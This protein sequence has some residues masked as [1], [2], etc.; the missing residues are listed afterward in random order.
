MNQRIWQ[1][2]RLRCLLKASPA[3]LQGRQFGTTRS[4]PPESG[5]PRNLDISCVAR[6]SRQY[7]W[8]PRS[9]PSV[10]GPVRK[11]VGL[12][13]RLLS[14]SVMRGQPLLSN[15]GS[16][17]LYARLLVRI[18]CGRSSPTSQIAPACPFGALSSLRPH[19]GFVV[20]P[21]LEKKLGA[22]FANF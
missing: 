16:Q 5:L 9:S 10:I 22:L 13:L 7:A 8:R 17:S 15:S 19:L 20:S 12:P 18:G 14:D 4:G 1:A 2:Q 6:A 21:G 3:G 11:R